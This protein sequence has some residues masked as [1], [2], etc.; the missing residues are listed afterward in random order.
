MEP[1][2]ITELGDEAL[3]IVWSDGHESLY[4]HRELRAAC[5]C[6]VCATERAKGDGPSPPQDVAPVKMEYVGRYALRFHWSD[7]HGTGIYSFALLRRLCTC[8]LCSRSTP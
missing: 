5:P 7:G 2:E 4:T 8:E 1:K 3:L 6:A